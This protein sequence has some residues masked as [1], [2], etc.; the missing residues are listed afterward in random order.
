MISLMEKLWEIY[1]ESHDIG[2]NVSLTVS[3]RNGA[4]TCV[5]KSVPTGAAVLNDHGCCQHG[6]HHER[7]GEQ[8]RQHGPSAGRAQQVQ[9]NGV[10]NSNATP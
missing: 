5:V 2:L 8:C 4:E 6:K 1:R 10:S 7:R 3:V 9:N